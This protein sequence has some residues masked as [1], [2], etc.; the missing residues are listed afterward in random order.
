MVGNPGRRPAEIAVIYGDPVVGQTLALLLAGA[1]YQVSEV[2]LVSVQDRARMERML[3]GVLV[4][5]LAPGL[6]VGL[7]DTFLGS[8]KREERFS[9]IPV[10]ELGTQP[11]GARYSADY[12]SMWPGR[13]EDLVRRIEKIFLEQRRGFNMNQA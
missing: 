9:H 2:S 4:I 1:G 10:L 5:V 12:T 8:L 13:T 3:E 7:R 6:E 11:E